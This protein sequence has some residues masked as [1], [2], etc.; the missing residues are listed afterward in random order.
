L[1]RQKDE[2]NPAKEISAVLAERE[3]LY[4]AGSDLVLDTEGA[5]PGA[6]A[7]NIYRHASFWGES[8]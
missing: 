3:P 6:L 7:E 1:G 5:T 2:Q 4:R 8:S